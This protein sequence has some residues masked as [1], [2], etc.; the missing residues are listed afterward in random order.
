MFPV[1]L[2]SLKRM[3]NFKKDLNTGER[4][5][6]YIISQLKDLHK[7]LKQVEGSFKDYDLVASDGYT[8]EVKFDRL[9]EKTNR[10]GIEYE[11][12]GKKSGISV[13]KAYEWVHVYKLYNQWVYSV[14][15]VTELKA[16]IKNNWGYL[17]KASGG[18]EGTSKMVL[19]PVQDF[20]EAFGFYPIT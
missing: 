14:I 2:E 3:G 16:Y 7:G 15:P 4:A 13:T 5:Q 20:A 9:S 18:D 10:V 6:N 17:K 19:I 12:F 1:Y 11:C 8:A